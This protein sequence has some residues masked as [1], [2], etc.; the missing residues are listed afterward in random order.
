MFSSLIYIICLKSSVFIPSFF[1]EEGHLVLIPLMISVSLVKHPCLALVFIMGVSR[2]SSSPP[3]P[4]L[5]SSLSSVLTVLTMF[6]K[7]QLT[8]LLSAL[9]PL[10]SSEVYCPIFFKASTAPAGLLE[11]AGGGAEGPDLGLCGEK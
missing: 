3:P 6:I 8:S 2:P 4:L 9:S 10:P 5:P 7:H 1:P 11:G